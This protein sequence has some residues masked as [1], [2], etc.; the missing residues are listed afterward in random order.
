MEF[1]Y[2][3]ESWLDF[4]TLPGDND[5]NGE[6]YL[7]EMDRYLYSRMKKLSRLRDNEQ[8][9]TEIC[10]ITESILNRLESDEYML[11][12][13][14]SVFNF[15]CQIARFN[16]FFFEEYAKRDEVLLFFYHLCSNMQTFEEGFNN[17]DKID[18]VRN[19]ILAI[20]DRPAIIQK[21]CAGM[22]DFS[23][24]N[25]FLARLLKSQALK[26]YIFDALEFVETLPEDELID[27]RRFL[28][29][30]IL[31]SL[32][33]PGWD[34]FIPVLRKYLYLEDQVI[35]FT[36]MDSLGRIGTE[37][38]VEVLK[39]YQYSAYEGFRDIDPLD[40]I[41]LD[42]NIISAQEGYMGLIREIRKSSADIV[43]AHIALRLLSS[44]RDPDVIRFLYRLLDDERHHEAQVHYIGEDESFVQ[45][46]IH[47]PLREGALL[48]LQNFDEDFVVSIVGE[49]YRHKKNFF[50]R[51][52][53]IL[54]KKKGFEK[55]WDDD[56]D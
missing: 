33:N 3:D 56:E 9:I 31:E 5:L 46:E 23:F 15:A 29:D 51:D 14:E 42:L 30:C 10:K 47:F 4:N 36:V 12:E 39:E 53:A 11:R 7:P 21:F 34:E 17:G 45:N 26:K 35:P 8:I 43:T 22:M 1:I 6:M 19:L 38:A 18:E 55:F 32:G 27:D 37:S 24:E 41:T 28:L 54:Y 25:I 48:L 52:L 40:G 20:T 2:F 16:G 49:K 50:Y 44:Y 13:A